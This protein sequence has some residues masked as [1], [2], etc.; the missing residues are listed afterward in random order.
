MSRATKKHPPSESSAPPGSAAERPTHPDWR[1]SALNTFWMRRMESGVTA[2][3]HTH[4][5]DRHCGTANRRVHMSGIPRSTLQAAEQD[6]VR[7]SEIVDAYE[8]ELGIAALQPDKDASAHSAG[9]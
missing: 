3:I 6:A 2:N 4:A 7:L 8:R 9:Q 1:R 5:P